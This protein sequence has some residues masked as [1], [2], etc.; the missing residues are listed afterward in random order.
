MKRDEAWRTHR[1]SEW[2]KGA[3]ASR[4]GWRDEER[5]RGKSIERRERVAYAPLGNEGAKVSAIKS[6]L[7]TRLRQQL[8]AASANPREQAYP[9]TK[10]ENAL[11]PA[12]E[13]VKT[14]I[15]SPA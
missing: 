5:G 6:R 1:R 8:A 12:A 2:E 15:R 14:T 4:L 11:E 13:T 10:S 9:P 7:R 3:A